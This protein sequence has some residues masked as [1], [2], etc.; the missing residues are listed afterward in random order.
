MD[1]EGQLRTA[2]E[3]RNQQAV[4]FSSEV[5]DDEFV[6]SAGLYYDALSAFYE[7]GALFGG[8]RVGC[9]DGV[10]RAA[11]PRGL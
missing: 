7:A 9:V 1:V 2:S 10:V 6:A 5:A 3:V 11:R 8:A 4:S